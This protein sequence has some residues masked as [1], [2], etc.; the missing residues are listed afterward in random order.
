MPLSAQAFIPCVG[1]IARGRGR[2]GREG[3]GEG[4]GRGVLGKGVGEK[5]WAA[6]C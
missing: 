1:C 2:G 4:D 5:G 6:R 3:K